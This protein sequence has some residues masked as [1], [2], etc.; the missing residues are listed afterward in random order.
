MPQFDFTNVFWPQLIWLT[1]VFA[2][3]Y[4]GV[5]RLTLPK[6]GNV[7]D[8]REAKI[9]GDIAAAESAKADADQLGNSGSEDMTAAQA[10]ARAIVQAAKTKADQAAAKRL[11]TAQDKVADTMVAAEGKLT[12]A[13]DA[14]LGEIEAV[15][16]DLAADMVEKLTGTRPAAVAAKAAALAA[17]K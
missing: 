1:I 4:F 9:A 7:V 8:Q 16:A 3:L 15:S 17:M 11:A 5:V 13:R 14:A 2:I 10:D 6:I 12:K